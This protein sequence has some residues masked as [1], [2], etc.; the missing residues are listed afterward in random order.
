M[1]NGQSIL[2][3]SDKCPVHGT[4]EKKTYNF[5]VYHDATV[6]TFTGCDCAI[7]QDP[8]GF[9]DPPQYYTDYNGAASRAR[10][11]QQGAQ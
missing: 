8:N 11:I 5:G 10:M 2:E 1:K 9:G 7:C 3:Y 6:T 4:P